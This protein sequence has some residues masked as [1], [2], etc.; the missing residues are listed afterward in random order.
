MKHISPWE[1]VPRINIVLFLLAVFCVFA[2]VGFASDSSNMG[3]QPVVRFAISVAVSAGFAVCYAAAGI[4]LRRKFWKA[5]LPLFLVEFV[6]M[7]LLANR[8]PDAPMPVQYGPA[9]TV[10]LQQRILFDSLAIIITVILGYIGFLAVSIREGRRHAKMQGEKAALES[11]MAAAREIQRLMVPEELPPTPGYR[12]ESVYRPAAQVGGDFFQVIP[13]KSGHTVVIVGD[14]SGK[15]LS[16]AMIVSMLIGMLGT[17]TSFTEE[18]AEIL[19]ELN[20]RL[21][22]RTHGGLVTCA[23]IRLEQSGQ[24]TL[25]NAG[26]LPPYLN[27]TEISFGGSLPLGADVSSSYDQTAF[28][29][30]TGDRML[31]LTDGIVEAQDAQG[32]LLGF[33]QVETLMRQGATAQALAEA[34]QRHGQADDITAISIEREASAGVYREPSATAVPVAS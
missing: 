29:V 31:L 33:A 10:Q 17:I 28:D 4:V 9:E 22:G 14:V 18:P 27:G 32:H 25:A 5:F 6:A 20:R 24:V 7:G 16:A 19:D 15:G 2:G 8:L 1:N 26:H 3:R 23:A 30:H 21:F 34:A 12:I 11:E 13:L